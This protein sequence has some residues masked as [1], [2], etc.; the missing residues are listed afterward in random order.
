M[1]TMRR[2][3]SDVPPL[4]C[5]RDVIARVLKC[6]QLD[7]EE[8]RRKR[9]EENDRLKAKGR[10]PK[11]ANLP[12]DYSVAFGRRFGA[13][14]AEALRFFFGDDVKSGELPSRTATGNKRLDVRYGTVEMGLGLGVSLKSVHQG[15]RQE[16]VAGFTHNRKR[17]D[18]ELRV[19][20]TGHHLRQPYAV[21]VAVVV[22][23][24]DACTDSDRLSS[25]ARWVQYLWPL[26]G[27]VEPTDR[28]DTFELVFIALYSRDGD[29]LGFHEVGGSFACPKRG[30]PNGLLSFPDF[31]KRVKLVF[32][33]R[34]GKDFTFAEDTRQ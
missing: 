17:N 27:R 31:V 15:E 29:E 14:I 3:R 10:R 18:E 30:R 11:S 22:L 5:G 25:F 34:N 21:L 9:E 13:E 24:F 4:P 28:P 8:A 7:V 6:T 33:K 26:T 19:E 2:R 16:G 23:P 32:D 1:M 12:L 20:A